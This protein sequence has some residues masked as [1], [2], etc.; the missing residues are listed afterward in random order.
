[1][2]LAAWARLDGG[3]G[4]WDPARLPK[5]LT[6]AESARARAFAN[7]LRRRQFLA[8]HGLLRLLAG[9]VLSI[10]PEAIAMSAEGRPRVESAFANGTPPRP[11]A[12]PIHLSLAH[13]G[14]Y[15]MA[16]AS[17]RG[18]VGIDIERTDQERD[19]A[20]LA[21]GMGWDAAAVGDKAGFLVTW[22][23]RE[24]EVKAGLAP[25]AGFARHACRRDFIATVVSGTEGELAWVGPELSG[26]FQ[27]T[28]TRPRR[29]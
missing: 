7:P 19:W 17:D 18:P 26:P 28:A 3:P 5:E 27:A 10:D 1:M 2:L 11:L 20:A 16:I 4:G 12:A 29:P 9:A 8:G 14:A 24:A 25:G 23:L 15:V 13:S 6:P 22:T 21:V